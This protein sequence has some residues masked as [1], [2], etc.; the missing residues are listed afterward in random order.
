MRQLES[1][2]EREGVSSVA[3]LSVELLDGYRASRKVGLLTATKE[4]HTLRQFC[5]FCMERKWLHE[6]PAKKIKA[7]KNVRPGPV[8]PYSAEE[9]AKLLFASGTFG[10]SRYERLR[11]RAMVLLLRHTGLRISDVAT[12][13]RD[14]IR[15][16]EMLLHT[17]KTGGTVK[18]PISQALQ[19]A[20]DTLPLPK[21]AGSDSQCSAN[22][23]G[24]VSES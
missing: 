2:S 1:F 15:D 24:R 18:L 8:E 5:G 11:A 4:L 10:K 22:D 23:E 19:Q 7:P 17:L 3:E 14:R 13:A 6:N 20:L 21:E 16:E 12:L 9:V